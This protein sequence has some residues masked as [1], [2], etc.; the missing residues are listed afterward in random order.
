MSLIDAPHHLQL[1][2][3]GKRVANCGNTDAIVFQFVGVD[4]HRY[5]AHITALDLHPGYPFY[6][7]HGRNNLVAADGV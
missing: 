2:D 5:F 1:V 3:A 4:L 6:P 7:A